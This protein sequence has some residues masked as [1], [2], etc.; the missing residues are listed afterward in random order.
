[1][2]KGLFGY[3]DSADGLA[4]DMSILK[5]EKELFAEDE[6]E[7]DEEIKMYSIY[8]GNDETGWRL[9][10]AV[11]EEDEAFRSIIRW[12]DSTFVNLVGTP[13]YSIKEEDGTKLIDFGS[14]I[15]FAKM[16]RI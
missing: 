6:Q 10:S 8:I 13:F 14:H 15:T 11:Q 12:R 3:G 4:Y 16:I 5:E 1:M 9:F 7:S 2:S